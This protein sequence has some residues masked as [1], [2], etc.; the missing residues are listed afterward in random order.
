MAA[1][2]IGQLRAEDARQGKADGAPDGGVDVLHAFG[3]TLLAQANVGGAGFGDDHIIFLDEAE[4][5]RPHPLLGEW[6]VRVWLEGL[7][8]EGSAWRRL[9]F[10]NAVQEDV[11]KLQRIDAHEELTV[12]VEV[13]VAEVV[14][15][16]VRQVVG[17]RTGV[18][19]DEAW[20]R[21]D[22]EVGVLNALLHARGGRGAV[23]G[24]DEQRV[25]LR[26][27]GLAGGE[28]GV[29]QLGLVDD[30]AELLR[31]A[32]AVGVLVDEDDGVLGLG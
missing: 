15:V 32:V 27:D 23:V 25:A 20:I 10:R 21:G 14:D 6:G 9:S 28:L 30:G 29:G 5:L 19:L 22:Q 7:G 17:E 12:G 1:L 11:E 8:L 3:H 24:A 4:H 16:G 31:E 13:L 18:D 2:R 26:Q